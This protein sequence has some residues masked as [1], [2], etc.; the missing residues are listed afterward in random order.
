MWKQEARNRRLVANFIRSL[1]RRSKWSINFGEL[2]IP[3]TRR[4]RASNRG[5]KASGGLWEEPPIMLHP[6]VCVSPGWSVI[7]SPCFDLMTELNKHTPHKHDPS[8]GPI[9]EPCPICMAIVSESDSEFDSGRSRAKTAHQGGWC[10]AR[11][12]GAECR[13]LSV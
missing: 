4:H 10:V 13:H 8:P 3:G 1:A 2:L 12:C 7:V 5:F 9:E 6:C 11:V